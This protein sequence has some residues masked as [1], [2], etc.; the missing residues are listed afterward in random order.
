MTETPLHRMAMTPNRRA[1]DAERFLAKIDNTG[2]CWI[3]QSAN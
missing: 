3:W 2:D 1:A